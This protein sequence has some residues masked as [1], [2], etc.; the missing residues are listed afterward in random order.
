MMYVPPKMGPERG[1]LVAFQFPPKCIVQWEM[2]DIL[3]FKLSF[4][5]IL[6]EMKVNVSK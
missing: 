1:G 3:M 2:Y 4:M 6:E 5:K